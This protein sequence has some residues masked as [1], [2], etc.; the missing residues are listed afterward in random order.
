MGIIF[1]SSLHLPS[2]PFISRQV[3]DYERPDSFGRYG[4][5][6][7]K[8]VPETLMAALTK[9]EETYREVVADPLFQ[10]SRNVSTLRR[11]GRVE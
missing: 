8:Y 10:V 11:A 7:G 2:S 9:L 3:A 5:F 4:I 1:W 6:G